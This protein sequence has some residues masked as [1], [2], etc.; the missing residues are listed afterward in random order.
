MQTMSG[1]VHQHIRDAIMVVINKDGDQPDHATRAARAAL[2]LQETAE[3]IAHDRVD[4]PRFR[5]G[6]NSGE[7]LAGVLG[8]ERG[9]R[10]HGLVGDTVNLAARLESAAP[11]GGV[12]I[13]AGTYER[14]PAGATV[15][16]LPPMQVKGKSEAVIAYILRGLPEDDS[17]GPGHTL[18]S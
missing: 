12:V 11:N 5:V 14:L 13:G 9:R 8:G 10:I 15:E 3:H 18:A 1:E 17:P 2:M 4:W 16:P 6:M 7:V